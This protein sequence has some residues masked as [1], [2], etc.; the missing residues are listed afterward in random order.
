MSRLRP[1]ILIAD[2][3]V[4]IAMQLEECLSADGYDVVAT[5]VSGEASVEMA[6]R[7]HPDLVLMDIVMPGKLDGIAAAEILFAEMQ[8]PVI[9]LTAY[10]EG[11]FIDRAK[12]I[13]PLGFVVKPFQEQE[14]KAAIELALYKQKMERR[15]AMAVRAGRVGVW[16]RNLETGE[17][18]IDPNLKAMMGYTDAEIA[19]SL[20]G[21]QKL[22]H[23]A[24][25][26]RTGDLVDHVLKTSDDSFKIEYRLKHKQGHSLWFLSQGTVCRNQAGEP[27]RIMGTDLEI[28][29]RKRAEDNLKKA[30]DSLDLRVKE[31]TAELMEA[32][33]KLKQQISERLRAEQ[34]LHRRE[35][36]LKAVALAAEQ[37]L[38]TWNLERDADTI[39]THLGKASEVCRAY[40]IATDDSPSLEG[41]VK[42]YRSWI[43]E[44]SPVQTGHTRLLSLTRQQVEDLGWLDA[45]RE[46]HI[47]HGPVD[48]FPDDIAHL[49]D[50]DKIKSLLLAPVFV[51]HELWGLIGF[52]D[53]RH[54][55]Q[56]TSFEREAIKTAGNILGAAL[57]HQ[58]ADDALRDSE[59]K[60]RELFKNESDAL[61][62]FDAET[63]LFEDANQATLDLYGY[64]KPQFL[65]LSAIDISAEKDRA[66]DTMHKVIADAANR[67]IPDYKFLK[68]DG[69]MF[70]GDI[71]AG[72]FTANGRRKVIGAVRD[73]TQRKKAEQHIQALTRKLMQAHESERMR[74]SRDLHDHVAQ[75]LSTLKIGFETLFDN[76]DGLSANLRRKAKDLSGLLGATISAVRDMAYNLRP[77]SLDQ[78]GLVRTIFLFCED[79]RH[80]TGIHIDFSSAGMEE[81]DLGS[82]TEINLYRLVQE[83]LYNIK[84]HACAS[85]AI[86]R[87]VASYPHIILRIEDNGTGFNIQNQMVEAMSNKRMGLRSMK[88]RTGLLG[89]RFKV[90]SKPQQGTRVVIKIP[91][92][93]KNRGQ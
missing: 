3:E 4:I 74:I 72:I 2:D 75:D 89:G 57:L 67:H 7:F 50:A 86:V 9:F 81:L 17:C 26:K 73:I 46:R 25:R 44:N 39:L 82:E 47:V 35:T 19:N 56:W 68:K 52:D 93:E 63:L 37:L 59:A 1:K 29:E 62:I 48:T 18:Y 20:K 22:I 10:A 54:R 8:I 77:P 87:L 84:K 61:M 76:Q 30:H 43:A 79:F 69:G 65:K 38:G 55:K 13:Q 66:H 15:Y 21:W 78:L 33:Q 88:E 41:F 90:E 34:A 80:A 60:Y 31:R 12:K 91:Y 5:V 45:W 36:I 28:N 14:V 27:E 11:E 58:R 53:C 42:Y 6:R 23:P 32:N 51:G 16:D 92:E 85:H 49:L 83:A 40:L 24:D 70:P 64:T 71:S